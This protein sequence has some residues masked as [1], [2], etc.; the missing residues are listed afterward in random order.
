MAAILSASLILGGVSSAASAG[1][2]APRGCF[3]VC[4]TSVIDDIA[5]SFCLSA[6]HTRQW[7]HW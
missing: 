2:R 1:A 5:L 3:T 6:L 4:T 7:R